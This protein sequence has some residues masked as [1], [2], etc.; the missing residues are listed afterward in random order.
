MILFGDESG[1][2]ILPPPL[3]SNSSFS[4]SLLLCYSCTET[5][6]YSSEAS[7]PLNPFLTPHYRLRSWFPLSPG[8]LGRELVVLHLVLQRNQGSDGIK[9]RKAFGL[10]YHQLQVADQDR[11]VHGSIKAEQ[12]DLNRTWL[13][14]CKQESYI[15]T[16]QTVCGLK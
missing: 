12:R 15:K 14:T 1:A 8:S 10:I 4:L 5:F 11:N 7:H 16:V 3:I 9:Q 6:P 2:V 13:S